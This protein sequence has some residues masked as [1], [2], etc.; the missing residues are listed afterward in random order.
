[1]SISLMTSS[2]TRPAVQRQIVLPLSKAL[3]IAWKSI[4]LR[5][6]R[7]LLVTSGIIL[8]LAFLMAI[9][10]SEA[11]TN[12]MRQWSGGESAG[13]QIAQLRARRDALVQNQ[14]DLASKMHDAVAT[15]PTTAPTSHT[16]EQILTNHAATREQ[17]GAF[18]MPEADLTIAMNAHA[19]VLSLLGQWI[20]VSKQLKQVKDE[21]TGPQQLQAL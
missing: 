13:S 10:T 17:L 5:L 1:M 11:M 3:E 18:P 20:D 12:A 19:E 9:L 8:A 6:S 7:S 15:P 21:L 14:T 16:L 2:A 4:R